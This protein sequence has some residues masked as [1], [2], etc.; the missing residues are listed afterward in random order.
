MP[1][2][3]DQHTPT[4]NP[5]DTE[6]EH[7]TYGM[8]SYAHT[9]NG[10]TAPYTA[11]P[12]GPS[13]TPAEG[14]D[15]TYIYSPARIAIYDSLS[16]APRIIQIDGAPT[17]EY[18]EHIASLTFKYAK[19]AGGRIPYTVIREVSENFIHAHFAEVIVSILDDGNTIRFADQGP[20]ISQK[21]MVQE[22]GF[23]SATEPMKR[24]IRGVGSGLPIVRDYLDM[25]H[26]YIEIEDNINRGSVVTISLVSPH[27]EQPVITPAADAPSLTENEEKV[28][29][30][31]LPNL[32]L[33]VTEV[34]RVTGVPV[35]SI[36]TAF[37]KMEKAGLVK[38]INKKRALTPEGHRIAISL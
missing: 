12:Q 31:L 17:H 2:P 16:S 38:K 30:A 5:I 19:E 1:L 35:A 6:V 37:S 18:I 3:E 7:S 23:S 20:G 36:H 28:L 4:G 32:A 10:G 26:G 25:S 33:G 11:T 27:T 24:Y 29:K 13:S 14:F 21:D 8:P 9:M 15:Y 34:N 22:P